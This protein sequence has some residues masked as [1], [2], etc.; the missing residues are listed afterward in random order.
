MLI[1]F[2]GR[3]SGVGEKLEGRLRPRSPSGEDCKDVLV[4]K[5]LAAE[6]GGG[7]VPFGVAPVAGVNVTGIAVSIRGLG[8][9]LADGEGEG[10]L[11]VPLGCWGVIGVV[12]EGAI[13]GQHR[14]YR[15]RSRGSR[16]CQRFSGFR[17]AV[18]KWLELPR[19]L[20][21]DGEGALMMQ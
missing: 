18:G 21:I 19:R 9:D 12:A 1:T 13:V 17:V 14:E 11:P 2:S 6:D 16:G 10:Q 7:P 5:G 3:C 8:V 20:R 15:G 4:V